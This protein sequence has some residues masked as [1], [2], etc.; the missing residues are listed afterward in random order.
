MSYFSGYFEA[1]RD[2]HC[3]RLLAVSRFGDWIGQCAFFLE[4]VRVL[5][6]RAVLDLY[7][8][9]KRRMPELA[10]SLCAILALDWVFNRPIYSALDFVT[11]AGIPK[12]TA[13]RFPG[14]LRESEIL[15]EI[16]PG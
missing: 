16:R 3:E 14:A 12:P 15:L 10:R 8:D 4:T 2:A 6:D 11:A 9:L 13:R 7:D 5:A 1:R